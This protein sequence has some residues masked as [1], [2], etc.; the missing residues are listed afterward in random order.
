MD[1]VILA[2][3]GVSSTITL[4]VA[5]VLC[6]KRQS[7]TIEHDYDPNYISPSVRAKNAYRARHVHQPITNLTIENGHSKSRDELSEKGAKESAPEVIVNNNVRVDVVK[8][9]SGGIP[10]GDRLERKDETDAGGGVPLHPA[11]DS[12]KQPSARGQDVH[13]QPSKRKAPTTPGGPTVGGPTQGR[14]TPSGS[15][16][17][18]ASSSVNHKSV[19]SPTVSVSTPA[20]SATTPPKVST[21]QG[22]KA[23]TKNPQRQSKQKAPTPKQTPTKA[24]A[25]LIKKEAPTAASVRSV[26]SNSGT[27]SFP[28]A[29]KT[30]PSPETVHFVK[31]SSTLP[32]RSSKRPAP[33]APVE[34]RPVK[35]TVPKTEDTEPSKNDI[36]K[37]DN[38]SSKPTSAPGKTPVEDLTS[39][40]DEGS[41]VEKPKRNSRQVLDR[42]P[43]L[44]KEN[45]FD[46]GLD[47]KQSDITSLSAG[48]DS[49]D[50]PDDVEGKDSIEEDPYSIINTRKLSEESVEH[51]KVAD[52]DDTPQKNG[53]HG[54]ENPVAKDDG[55]VL[56][57]APD[58]ATD[59][60]PTEAGAKAE[61]PYAKVIKRNKRNRANVRV[62]FLEHPEE[63]EPN[64][65]PT[66]GPL[67]SMMNSESEDG[68]HFNNDMIISE[69]TSYD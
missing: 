67:V 12:M 49:F 30:T 13:R 20:R 24:A 34:A 56:E 66:P 59:G 25:D 38:V 45:S 36:A 69:G 52:N 3:V 60:S 55:I 32:G 21:S 64:D 35:V 58:D 51:N 9:T 44:P 14:P 5:F 42:L 40:S 47:V 46:S 10:S 57:L 22:Q 62:R 11:K 4:I 1:P 15:S 54:E 65:P 19:T 68:K 41:V 61:P 23:T 27:N 18:G 29:T 50:G 16:H 7:F 8:E 53:E 31:K 63:A 39:G 33:V 28:R 43:S 26:P 2:I 48:S 37:L 6:A 17:R